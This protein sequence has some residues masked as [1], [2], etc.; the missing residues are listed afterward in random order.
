MD[1]SWSYFKLEF[2][3]IKIKIGYLIFSFMWH[4]VSNDLIWLDLN[5]WNIFTISFSQ[6][7]FRVIAMYR[8]LDKRSETPFPVTPVYP[9][10]LVRFQWLGCW[11]YVARPY[12]LDSYTNIY[13]QVV[14]ASTSILC[15]FV[16][17]EGICMGSKVGPVRGKLYQVGTVQYSG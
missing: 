15:I 1:I 3:F 16:R 10:P 12:V 4:E 2:P 5:F 9:L 8:F 7:L 14:Q 6:F 13:V 17:L 11:N